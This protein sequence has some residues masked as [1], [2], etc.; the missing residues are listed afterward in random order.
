MQQVIRKGIESFEVPQGEGYNVFTIT[1]SVYEDGSITLPLDLTGA[2]VQALQAYL[3]YNDEHMQELRGAH[4]EVMPD[5]KAVLLH[6]VIATFKTDEQRERERIT[7]W[8]L[9]Q[10][11]MQVSTYK[12]F[13]SWF[14][15]TYSRYKQEWIEEGACTL[16]DTLYSVH[17]TES[18]DGSF[19][20][21]QR[22]V[23]IHYTIAVH[24]DQTLRVLHAR[25]EKQHSDD[26]EEAG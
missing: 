12:A 20:Y 5:E 10:H 8:V 13:I 11:R 24:P 26:E 21:R 23:T 16:E 6:Q 17:V 14:E 19:S 1:F 2:Q 9:Q 22:Q 7:A 15:E 18:Y 3:T 25:I 4:L